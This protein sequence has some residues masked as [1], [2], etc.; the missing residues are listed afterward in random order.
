MQVWSTAP[1]RPFAGNHHAC[2]TINNR[3]YL[4]G[5]LSGGG[6]NV[7]IFSPLTNSWSQGATLPYSVGMRFVL[8]C[9]SLH[10]VEQ[11]CSVKERRDLSSII[12]W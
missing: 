8:H 9:S 1:G 2:E 7:Q 6:Q 10:C 5:G 4:F 3:L 12:R 11:C